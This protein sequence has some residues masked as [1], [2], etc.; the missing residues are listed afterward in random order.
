MIVL[1]NVL[2]QPLWMNRSIST[3]WWD[4]SPAGQIRVVMSLHLFSKKWQ[5]T[6]MVRSSRKEK[7]CPLS[8]ACAHHVWNYVQWGCAVQYWGMTLNAKVEKRHWPMMRRWSCIAYEPNITIQSLVHGTNQLVS[9]PHTN[10]HVHVH[11]YIM[12]TMYSLAWRF[13]LENVDLYFFISV[14]HSCGVW[15]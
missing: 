15:R 2:D 9:G 7:A 8:N 11:V 12:Q 5:F 6:S 3:P 4:V 10:I 13:C 14:A 1:C